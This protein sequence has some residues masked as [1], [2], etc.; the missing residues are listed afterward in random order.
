VNL[1]ANPKIS[2]GIFNMVNPDWP[3]GDWK[4]TKGVQITGEAKL[5][6]P[7]DPEY[8]Q[9]MKAYNWEPF[10][11]A[12]GRTKADGPKPER[13][14]KVEAKKIEYREGA[15]ML[16]GYASGQVWEVSA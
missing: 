7:N 16:E 3:D 6:T 2:V 4:R 11:K 1:A 14:I 9:A 8:A 12:L 15:L 10:L 13:M 5:L